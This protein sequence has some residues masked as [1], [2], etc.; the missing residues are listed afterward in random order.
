MEDLIG[1]IV[2]IFLEVILVW[3]GE[4]VKFVFSFGRYKPTFN[5]SFTAVYGNLSSMFIGIAFWI[6]FG[7]AIYWIS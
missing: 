5:K 2:F 7:V 1:I 4:I 3:T 6:A